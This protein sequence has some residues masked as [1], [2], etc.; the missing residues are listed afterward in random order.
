MRVFDGVKYRPH[1]EFTS[2]SAARA[3]AS[4]YRASGGRAR[5]VKGWGGM[6]IVYTAPKK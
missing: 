6:W 1:D 4:R 5:V 2:K 3:W